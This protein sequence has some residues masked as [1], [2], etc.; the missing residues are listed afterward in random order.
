MGFIERRNG[1]Y[2]ARHRDPLGGQRCETFTRKADAERYLR[3]MQVEIERGRWDRSRQRPG[4]LGA[5]G[6]G[7]PGPRPAP[8]ADDPPT[9]GT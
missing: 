7:L 4:A 3:E 5:L 9:G 8:L 2:R 1:R 6:K